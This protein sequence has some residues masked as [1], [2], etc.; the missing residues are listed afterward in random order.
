[1]AILLSCAAA[2]A[3]EMAYQKWYQLAVGKTNQSVFIAKQQCLN[4]GHKIP[5]MGKHSEV[6]WWPMKSRITR[7]QAVN[8]ARCRC[9]DY[10]EVQAGSVHAV[11]VERLRDCSDSMYRLL[12]IFLDFMGHN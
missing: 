4:R 7:G 9:A 2:N 3:K 1:M 12:G 5:S 11:N 10:I 8:A 6:Q